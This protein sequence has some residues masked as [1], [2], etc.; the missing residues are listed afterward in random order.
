MLNDAQITTIRRQ[1]GLNVT[2]ASLYPWVPTF[3]TATQIL[4]TL[5][6]TSEAEVTVI[7]GRLAGLEARLDNTTQGGRIKALDVG[8]IKLNPEELN[9][10]WG[11]IRRWR[12]ELSVITGIPLV[13]RGSALLVV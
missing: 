9:Q 11:E 3:Y 2:S 4:K 13:G 6:P 8:P 5:P 10:L 7:L 1:L 12:H